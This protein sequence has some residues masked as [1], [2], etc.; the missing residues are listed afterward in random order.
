MERVVRRC[1]PCQCSSWASPL[2]RRE[3]TVSVY[4]KLG[5]LADGLVRGRTRS[6]RFILGELRPD[7]ELDLVEQETAA[8]AAPGRQGQG[9]QTW[10]KR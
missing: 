3:R 9:W 8:V 6:V 4:V 10:P 1:H 5:E 7:E 2:G